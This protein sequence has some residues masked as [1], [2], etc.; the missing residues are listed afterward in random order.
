LVAALLFVGVNGIK[1]DGTTPA[2]AVEFGAPARHFDAKKDC[3]SFGVKITSGAEK[4][5]VHLGADS[6][7]GEEGAGVYSCADGVVRE[8]RHYAPDPKAPDKTSFGHV[9]VIEHTISGGG[10]VCSVYAHLGKDLAVKTGERVTRGQKIATVGLAFSS[11]NGNAPA[12]LHFAMH[13]GGFLSR[14]PF[15]A[16]FIEFKDGKNLVKGQIIDLEEGKQITVSHEEKKVVLPWNENFTQRFSGR[17][18]WL[19]EFQNAEEKILLWV[20]PS[21]YFGMKK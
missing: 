16:V 7:V 3:A 11:E 1:A 18:L 5:R 6:C 10:S 4:G 13:D 9:V 19:A 21:D 14:V 8:A 12:H 2:P 15:P 17:A 20:N